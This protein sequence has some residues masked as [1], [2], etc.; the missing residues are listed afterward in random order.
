MNKITPRTILI[1]IGFLFAWI[2]GGVFVEV[3][4][5]PTPIYAILVVG[6]EIAS[7]ISVTYDLAHDTE[8]SY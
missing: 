8:N 7:F 3:L 1:G 5:L 4:H 2:V 6:F